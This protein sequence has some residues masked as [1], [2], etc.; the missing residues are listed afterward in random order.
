M[1]PA[2]RQTLFAT[3]IALSG[4]LLSGAYVYAHMAS[5]HGKEWTTHGLPAAV[6]QL[7]YLFSLVAAGLAFTGRSW[8]RV[9]GVLLGLFTLVC[10]IQTGFYE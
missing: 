3:S 1:T 6:I 5:N 2:R 9:A 4:A 8:W 10:W 7:S